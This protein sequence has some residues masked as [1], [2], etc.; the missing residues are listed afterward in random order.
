MNW[1]EADGKQDIEQVFARSADLNGDA[2]IVFVRALCAISQEEL[3]P[4]D[5]AD[6]PRS[7]HS[8]IL[9]ESTATST[10][11]MTPCTALFQHPLY[12]IDWVLD[13][14]AARS[15]QC[16]SYQSICHHLQICKHEHELE[17]MIKHVKPGVHLLD[18][19]IRCGAT[20]LG[21]SAFRGHA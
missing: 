2:V 18:H 19:T 3:V 12:I 10:L 1:A 13:R 14:F 15:K 9:I 4:E 20:D 6:P 21:I 11:V 8:K 5:P 16:S 17:W 7:S